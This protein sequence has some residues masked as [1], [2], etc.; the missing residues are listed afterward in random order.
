MPEAVI[1]ELRS[2]VRVETAAL[3]S[4]SLCELAVTVLLRKNTSR[5]ATADKRSILN[6]PYLQDDWIAF[7]KKLF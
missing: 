7:K 1:S 5:T 3:G 2:C 4:P 6:I